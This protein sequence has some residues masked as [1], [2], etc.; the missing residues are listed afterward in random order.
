MNP[1]C[2]LGNKNLQDPID[3]YHYYINGEF[4]DAAQDWQLYLDCMRRGYQNMYDATTAEKI[5]S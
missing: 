5:S 4:L 1:Y 2:V 3:L